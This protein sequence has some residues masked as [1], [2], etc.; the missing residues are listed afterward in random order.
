MLSRPVFCQGDPSAR[1]FT[2]EMPEEVEVV[3]HCSYMRTPV[4][5][6][7]GIEATLSIKNS[8]R[9]CIAPKALPA[10]MVDICADHLTVVIDAENARNIDVGHILLTAFIPLPNE[11][12]ISF[13]TRVT[14]T[15][16]APNG[17]VITLDLEIIGL[18]ATC[19]GRMLLRRL[20]GIVAQYRKLTHLMP[21]SAD[22]IELIGSSA[23][24][25]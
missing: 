25:F 11:S 1:V 13:T 4:P 3:R 19:E 6:D 7:I 16:T 22:H 2:L 9:P 24:Y 21:S 12:Q 15:L 20:C 23:A 10:T 8:Q 14:H 18:E 17:L 5:W